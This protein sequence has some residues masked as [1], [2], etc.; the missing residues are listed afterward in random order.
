[1]KNM[2]TVGTEIPV[3]TE[4][5]CAAVDRLVTEWVFPEDTCYSP[6][7]LTMARAST[8]TRMLR[9]R[10][11]ALAAEGVN[12]LGQSITELL[13]DVVPHEIDVFDPDFD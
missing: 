3:T 6:D 7:A 10:M 1:M 2:P 11:T 4:A 9:A 8:L 5:I 13:P 12:P